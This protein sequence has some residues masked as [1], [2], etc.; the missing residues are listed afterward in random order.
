MPMVFSSRLTC[1]LGDLH[2]CSSDWLRISIHGTSF[3]LL[4][5]KL[6]GGLA[7]WPQLGLRLDLP[8]CIHYVSTQPTAFLSCITHCH[9]TTG[10]G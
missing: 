5:S 3:S 6:S 2:F 1:D 8:V 4:F 10:G 7:L 9:V